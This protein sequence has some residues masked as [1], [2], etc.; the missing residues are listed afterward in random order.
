[1]QLPVVNST[2][3]DDQDAS[4]L[5]QLLSP[6]VYSIQTGNENGPHGNCQNAENI[7]NASLF[8][9]LEKK[10]GLFIRCLPCIVKKANSGNHHKE[11]FIRKRESLSIFLSPLLLVDLLACRGSDR[12]T[13]KKKKVKE[14]KEEKKRTLRILA[15]HIPRRSS[16]LQVIFFIYKFF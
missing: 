2:A 11:K 9:W 1:M 3:C 10:F 15:I 4:S 12:R 8:G 6:T 14:K 16:I 13:R 5:L 7:C